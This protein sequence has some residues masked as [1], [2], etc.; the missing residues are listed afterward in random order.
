MVEHLG[1]LRGH[2]L[3]LVVAQLEPR[4]AGD[5][6]HLFTIE[7]LSV[8][9]LGFAAATRP[10]DRDVRAARPAGAMPSW[11]SEKYPPTAIPIALSK[12]RYAPAS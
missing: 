7:H 5:V 2:P 10:H 11:R 1:Q 8:A 6:E 9:I 12:P 3:D 4:E